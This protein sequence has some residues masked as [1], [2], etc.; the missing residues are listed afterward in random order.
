MTCA[1]D[2]DENDR[3]E[4]DDESVYFRRT[5]QFCEP[6]FSCSPFVNTV[7]EGWGARYYPKISGALC[8]K[9]KGD[10]L[11]IAAESRSTSDVKR[12]RTGWVLVLKRTSGD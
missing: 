9:L 5:R 11:V 8:K 3:G 10:N 12:L 2:R 4:L 1:N 7:G 6:L